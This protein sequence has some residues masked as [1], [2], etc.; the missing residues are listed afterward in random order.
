M[1]RSILRGIAIAAGTGIALGFGSSFGRRRA[2]AQRRSHAPASMDSVMERLDRIETRV[3][4]AEARPDP[5]PSR[6]VQAEIAAVRAS[7]DRIDERLAG[8]AREIEL[9]R[10]QASEAEK[11]AEAE[12][13]LTE[14]RFREVAASLP[15][16]IEAVVAPRL[17]VLRLRLHSETKE[18]VDR[19]LKV[20]EESLDARVSSRITSL[21]QKLI[22]Q[23]AALSDLSQRTSQA[24]VNLQRL[25]AAVERL[26]EQNV[27]Q[28]VVAAAPEPTFLDLPFEA[29]LKKAL[30]ATPATIEPIRTENGFLRPEFVREDEASRR[31]RV[32][33][34]HI[35]IAAAAALIGARFVR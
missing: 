23:S 29:E 1:A 11:L 35:M 26:C 5:T 19:A 4:A 3:S 33:L 25:V 22:D 17:E 9:L 2:E 31:P 7:L 10:I 6:E 13:G 16:E 8:Q 20:F 34:A 30:S 15:A 27:P 12:V 18:S 14:R 24:D 21:E 28:P 32:P